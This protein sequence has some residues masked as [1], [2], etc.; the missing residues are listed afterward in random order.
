MQPQPELGGARAMLLPAAALE[1]TQF[2]LH[3]PANNFL[4]KRVGYC[5]NVNLLDAVPKVDGFF[6]LTP[7]ESDQLLTFIY[8]VTNADF[9][10]LKDFMG[11]A[12]TTAPGELLKWQA[13]PNFL[14][15]VTAGQRPV[16]LDETN[17]LY[18]LAGSNFDGSKIVLLSPEDQSSVNTISNVTA[19][20]LNTHFTDRTV[21]AQVN[22]SAPTLTVIAQTYYHNWHATVDGQP[23]PLLR[24]NVA[25]QAVPVPA[26][27]HRVRLKYVDTAFLW[28]ARI[29]LAAIGLSGVMFMLGDRRRRV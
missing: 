24:A 1:L 10:R 5:A 14:P 2:A 25:F 28:G 9:S 17:A 20:V 7:R 22:A 19:T 12:Q 15:L 23:V 27:L 26:G 8:S 6:S 11:V 16:Y 29:S 18:T 13:R 21:E 3:D 4:A